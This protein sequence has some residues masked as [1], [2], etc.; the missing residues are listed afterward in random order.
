MPSGP[1]AVDLLLQADSCPEFLPEL[2]VRGT[3]ASLTFRGRVG[4]TPESSSNEDLK[5][6][7]LKENQMT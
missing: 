2:R 6:E 4:S 7:D 5:A 1:D 3:Y